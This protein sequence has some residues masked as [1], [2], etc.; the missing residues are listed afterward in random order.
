MTEKRALNG[1]TVGVPAAL[2]LG[3]V[4]L[5][6]LGYGAANAIE[7]IFDIPADLTYDSSMDLLYLSRHAILGFFELITA[8]EKIENFLWLAVASI[9]TGLTLTLISIGLPALLGALKSRSLTGRAKSYILGTRSGLL[10]RRSVQ[11]WFRKRAVNLIPLVMGIIAPLAGALA[12][13]LAT[14]P[15]ITIPIIGYTSASAHFNKW[16]VSAEYCSPIR[17][18]S[19]RLNFFNIHAGPPS[20]KSK[21]TPCLSLW[22]DGAL[23]A[24]GRH[25][26]S[27]DST[28]ILFDPVSGNV[29]IEPTEGRSIRV[30]G[31]S[32]TVLA[33]QL[34]TPLT[35]D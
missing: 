6:L 29:V 30:S 26:A 2:A 35:D 27:T 13:M 10:P 8:P 9:G 20:R 5:S 1:F 28:V 12:L 25:V 14:I 33:D 7:E 34:R 16:I 15:F 21:T 22:Q 18:R 31:P 19:E 17:S 11:Q 23:V 3:A 24:E 4:T 32:G